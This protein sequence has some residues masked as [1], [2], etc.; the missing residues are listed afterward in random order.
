MEELR[1]NAFAGLPLT[2][3][4]TLARRLEA[5][6]GIRVSR[7]DVDEIRRLLF[8]RWHVDSEKDR[9][10]DAKQMRAAW[11]SLYALTDRALEAGQSV[12]LAATFS[13][14]AYVE[15][16]L[17]VTR[18]YEARVTLIYCSAPD[19][20]IQ[21]RVA[22]R[23][24]EDNFSNIMNMEGYYRVKERFEVY[25]DDPS[26][27]VLYIDTSHSVQECLGKIINYLGKRWF[28]DKR[29]R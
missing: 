2:G 12:I 4:S 26:V 13:R 16:L 1:V 8:P 28:N 7:I 14:R 24:A 20:T 21:I 6:L 3:K 9:E 27:D 15:E 19:E 22:A 25:D 11:K 23:N 5:V 29:R 17:E 18:K 10:S